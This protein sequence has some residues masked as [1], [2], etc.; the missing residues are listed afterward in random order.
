MEIAPETLQPKRDLFSLA[1]ECIHNS[2]LIYFKSIFFLDTISLFIWSELY[3]MLQPFGYNESPKWPQFCTQ[4]DEPWLAW[5]PFYR[6]SFSVTKA[7][8]IADRDRRSKFTE[9]IAGRSAIAK[10][11]I[12]IAKYTIFFAIF[13]AN[14][15]DV[16]FSKISHVHPE[17]SLKDTKCMTLI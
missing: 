2:I 10:S 9:K 4:I 5:R 14:N 3:I 12:G 17:K 11:T 7:W 16:N 13:F 8:V 6:M 1:E 15:I